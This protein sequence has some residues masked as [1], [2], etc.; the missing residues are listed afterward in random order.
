VHTE[1]M[2]GDLISYIKVLIAQ[3]SLQFPGHTYGQS[4]YVHFLLRGSVRR[5]DDN[6]STM[7]L[8]EG[9]QVEKTTRSMNLQSH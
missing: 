6:D 5:V 2:I 3:R 9:R 1:S 7:G 4:L 8:R